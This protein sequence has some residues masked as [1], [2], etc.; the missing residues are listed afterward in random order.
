MVVDMFRW[1]YGKLCCLWDF[2][3]IRHF[4]RPDTAWTYVVHYFRTRT[5]Q[6]CGASLLP[7]CLNLVTHSII[8]SDHC[9]HT[10]SF[11]FV[12]SVL[13]AITAWVGRKVKGESVTDIPPNR[14]LVLGLMSI[15]STFCA[16]RALRYVLIITWYGA[17][18]ENAK[19][20]HSNR[21]L[22]LYT[23][24]CHLSHSSTCSVLQTR[25]SVTHWCT[26]REEVSTPK[27]HQRLFDCVWCCDVHG[28][29]KHFE[30]KW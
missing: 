20:T 29:W 16:I 24:I 26:V 13:A 10:V 25:S 28:G 7:V 6:I 8:H 11:L 23:Q 9:Q 2:T 22:V 4:R 3:R 30:R 17:S 18:C 12:T 21:H 27:I 1:N 5:H 14:F 19:F 15:G